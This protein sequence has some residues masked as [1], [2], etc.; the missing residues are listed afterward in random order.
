MQLPYDVRIGNFL[1]RRSCLCVPVILLSE[2][3]KLHMRKFRFRNTIVSGILMMI[4]VSL[5]SPSLLY[6]QDVGTLVHGNVTDSSRK[7]ISGASV[8]NVKTG[9]GTST[10]QDGNF[11][12]RAVK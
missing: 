5:L 9:K 6:A 4:A 11:T 3:T 7:P 8:L 10:D 1:L 2:K 12:I